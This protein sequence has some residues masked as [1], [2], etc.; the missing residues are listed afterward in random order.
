MSNNTSTT[1]TWLP[2]ALAGLAASLVGIGLARFAYTPLL[3][4]LIEAGWFAEITAIYLGAANLA[5]YLAGALGGKWLATH[6][7]P[8]RLLR[9]MMLLAVVSFF[10]CMQ[11]VS[12]VWF[13]VWRFLAGVSGGV[14]MVMAA[15]TVLPHV[16]AS[17]RGLAGGIIFTGVGLGIALSGTLVPALIHI[18]V[19]ETWAGLGIISLILSLAAWRYWPMTDGP[20]QTPPTTHARRS[21]FSPAFSSLYVV[22]ALAAVGMVAHMVFLVDYAARELKL[23]IAVGSGYWVIFGIGAALGP[24]AAGKIADRIGFR[25]TLRIF[26]FV[27]SL[28]VALTVAGSSHLTLSLSSFLVGALVP[29]IVPLIVGRAHQM[30]GTDAA[31][32]RSAWSYATVGFSVGQAG[33]AYAFSYIYE[34]TGHYDVLFQ[35]SAAAIALAFVIDMLTP[36][37]K[38]QT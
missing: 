9:F 21:A 5:G 27:Q 10:A 25:A 2:F 26:L 38:E 34:I 7:A 20:A 29:G 28:A 11:P 18:G 4:T 32:Q 1:Q 30:S 14:L 15:A 31:L 36:A 6:F 8:H 33:A 16:P 13:F 23:G 35:I 37:P 3:P 24:L 19:M 12:F 17:K 22:Y